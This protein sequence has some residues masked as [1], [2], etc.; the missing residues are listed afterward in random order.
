MLSFQLFL[1]DK[2]LTATD[3][4]CNA[5]VVTLFKEA[6]V[7][8][9]PNGQIGAELGHLEEVNARLTYDLFDQ[10]MVTVFLLD[11]LAFF[12]CLIIEDVK[13]ETVSLGQDL[14]DQEF[15]LWVRMAEID[16]LFT[17]DIDM[18]LVIISITDRFLG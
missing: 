2:T 18:C 16:L 7:V 15:V 10:N 1:L 17:I 4:I 5:I 9:Q 8:F 6:R 3:R 11:N 12:V 13:S 14:I